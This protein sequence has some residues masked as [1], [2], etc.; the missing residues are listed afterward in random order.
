VQEEKE[1]CWEDTKGKE[2]FVAIEFI[3][4]SEKQQKVWNEGL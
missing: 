3:A 1:S 2:L 4:A